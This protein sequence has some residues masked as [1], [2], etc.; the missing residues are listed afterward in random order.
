VGLAGDVEG[1]TNAS[2]AER[3][4]AASSQRRAAGNWMSKTALPSR[5]LLF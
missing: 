5:K 3:V 1:I 4:V 2:G